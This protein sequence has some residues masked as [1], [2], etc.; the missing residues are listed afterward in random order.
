MRAKANIGVLLGAVALFAA[1]ALLGAAVTRAALGSGAG[2]SVLSLSRTAEAVEPA[3]A[4]APPSASAEA[5]AAT[6]ISARAAATE[7]RATNAGRTPPDARIPSDVLSMAV[8]RAPFAPDRQPPAQRY[9]LPDQIEPPRRERPPPERPAP[10]QFRVL[11]TVAAPAGSVAVVQLADGKT[12]VMTVGQEMEGYRVNAIESGAVVMS[13]Q[14]WDLTF[15][16]ADAQPIGPNRPQRDANGR[17]IQQDRGQQNRTAAGRGQAGAL[18]QLQR[19]LLGDMMERGEVV[20]PGG[21][22]VDFRELRFEGDVVVPR[23]NATRREVQVAPT[24]E[25]IFFKRP[26]PPEGGR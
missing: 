20:I 5:L 19:A 7:A 6:S 1:V 21:Q 13:G 15:A 18:A 26:A 22:Y 4:D 8:E 25:M 17:I 9:L 24:P 12:R 11:G 14:G 23:P 16:V 10:P 2:A 3:S